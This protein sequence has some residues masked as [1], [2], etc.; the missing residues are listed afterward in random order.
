MLDDLDEETAFFLADFAERHPGK[1]KL[2]FSIYDLGQHT[3]L[4]TTATRRHITV[5]NELLDFLDK[6]ES[7]TYK[8]N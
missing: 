3:R 1:T 6:Q 4:Q 7:I 5:N 2:R 8:I